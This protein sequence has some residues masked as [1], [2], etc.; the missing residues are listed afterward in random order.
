MDAIL[1]IFLPVYDTVRS[2]PQE[3]EIEPIFWVL[4]KIKGFLSFFVG[5]QL[6][7]ERLK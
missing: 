7:Q 1:Y 6:T 5:I 2:S 3:T 4:R